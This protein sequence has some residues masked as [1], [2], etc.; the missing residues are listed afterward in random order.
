[1]PWALVYEHDRH[2]KYVAGDLGTLTDAIEHGAP[3]RVR[4][5]YGV[6]GP[7]VFRDAAA[8][9][10]R[11]GHVHAQLSTVVSC[12][13]QNDFYGDTATVNEHYEPTGL[14]F[15]DNP[16]WYFEIVSTR[17]DTDKSRWGIGDLKSRRRNQGK[18]AMK[19]FVNR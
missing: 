15:L 13:F 7:A 19:W 8:L 11:D 10:I 12:S 3:V 1:M 6:E 4:L 14:R 2:G 16:Y 5:D 18:Y 17:G 9:W